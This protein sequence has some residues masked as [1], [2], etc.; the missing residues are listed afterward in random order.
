MEGGSRG[1]ITEDPMSPERGG[2]W[3]TVECGL[4]AGAPGSTPNFPTT[5]WLRDLQ[6]PCLNFLYLQTGYN[7]SPS[8]GT[9]M[10]VSGGRDGGAVSGCGFTVVTVVTTVALTWVRL[11]PSGAGTHGL[12][13][14]VW[15]PVSPC[16]Q[17]WDLLYFQCLVSCLL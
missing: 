12:A 1:V 16:A 11:S 6:L 10:E 5:S 14:P 17:V 13:E 4:W 7:L 15:L 9:L 3:S 8:T 2:A